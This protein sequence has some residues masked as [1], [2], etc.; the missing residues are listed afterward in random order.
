MINQT[1]TTKNQQTGS[2][3]SIRMLDVTKLDWGFRFFVDSEFD[4]YKAAYEYRNNIHGT[5]VEFAKGT[6]QWMVT[7][8]NE[9]AATIN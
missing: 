7:V 8:F 4:A 6:Q 2:V 9:L 5:K 1:L 3:E